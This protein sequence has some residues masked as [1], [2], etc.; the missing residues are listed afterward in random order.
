MT[1][2]AIYRLHLCSLLPFFIELTYFPY[3]GDAIKVSGMWISSTGATRRTRL[4]QSFTLKEV[5]VQYGL[6]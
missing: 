5:E 6:Y 3:V 2:A 4:L 1:M